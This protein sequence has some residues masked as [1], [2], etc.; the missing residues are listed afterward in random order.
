MR[1]VVKTQQKR[2]GRQ[3]S[4]RRVNFVCKFDRGQVLVANLPLSGTAGGGAKTFKVVF[5]AGATAV[6]T[7][8]KQPDASGTIEWTEPLEMSLHVGDKTLVATVV[9]RGLST[10]PWS[11]V[12]R[13]ILE[14]SVKACRFIWQLAPDPFGSGPTFCAELEALSPRGSS[15]KG[16]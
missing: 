8:P 16:E 3:F 13:C 7:Y 4:Y 9:S 11:L 10:D 2:P 14:T 12:T 6:E 15:R 5:S 1:M